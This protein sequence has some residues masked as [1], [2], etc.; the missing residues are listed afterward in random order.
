MRAALV[1][2]M[3]LSLTGLAKA[4]PL[5][6]LN[7]AEDKTYQ[8]WQNVPLTERKIAFITE[9][10]RGYGLYVEKQDNVFRKG[11]KLITYVEPIGYGWKNLPGRKFETNFVVD[12]A[13]KDNKGEVIADQKGFMK[14]VMQSHNASMEFSMDFTLTLTGMPAGKYLLTYT[15]HDISSG[16][17]SSFDQ[18]FSIA[19]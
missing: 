12:M 6:D 14:N 10:S 19:D 15:I 16:Q 13:I 17:D 18:D 4:D 8:A 9:S 2:A 7:D 1:L 3:V 5:D 11:E